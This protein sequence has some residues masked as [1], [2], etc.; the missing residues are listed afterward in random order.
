M[1]DNDHSQTIPASPNTLP[2]VQRMLDEARNVRYLAEDAEEALDRAATAMTNLAAALNEAHD[3]IMTMQGVDPAAYDWPDHSPQAIAIREAETLLGRRLAKT[4]AWTMFRDDGEP[5]CH[6]YD[7]DHPDQPD[8]GMTMNPDFLRVFDVET[9]A[10]IAHEANRALCLSQG[11]HSQPAFLAAPTWQ[12]DSA[13]NGVRFHLDNPDASPSASH[14]NWM[15]E[16]VADG[17]IYG[18]TKDPAAKMHPCIVPYE[19]L[20]AAQQAK[21]HLFRGIVHALAPFVAR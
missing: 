10:R 7:F 14:D 12:Q 5:T 17:W 19:E 18:E 1:T 8:E 3:A 11:D 9:V 16:K 15:A 20:P 4:E 2:K 6:V 13:L 21:D